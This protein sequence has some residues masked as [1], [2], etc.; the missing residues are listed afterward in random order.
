[1]VTIVHSK[2]HSK[3]GCLLMGNS[4]IKME[5]PMKGTSNLINQRAKAF[6]KIK[7]ELTTGS[8]LME[9]SDRGPYNIKMA[10]NIL[11][12]FKMD[13]NMELMDSMFTRMGI[14]LWGNFLEILSKTE[15]TLQKM[16]A[17]ITDSFSQV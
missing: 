11:A 14:N 3:M 13:R 2:V 9:S 17:L 7:V 8:L 6:G 1:M 15:Y 5:T 12:I 4:H 10:A 16:V